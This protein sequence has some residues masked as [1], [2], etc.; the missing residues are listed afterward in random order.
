M[1]KK[2]LLFFSLFFCFSLQAQF[3][4]VLISPD[5]SD[6]KYKVKE[7]VK[8]IVQVYNNQVLL[9]NAV[10]DYELGPEFFPSVKKQ[11]VVLKGGKTLLKSRMEEPGFLRC[12]VT[13]KVEGKSY[14]GMVT[15]AVEA[16]K[17]Q[18][19]TTNP[20]DFD[21]FWN[22]E[23]ANARKL[24]LDAKMALMPERCTSTQNVYHVNF[25]NELERSRIYGILIV[26]KKPGKY[27]AVLQVPGAG[28]SPY[29]GLNLG[30]D[31]ITLEIGIHGIPVNLPREVYDALGGTVLREYADVN[32]NNKDTYFYK[33]VYIGCVRAID[34]LHSLP[35]FD[36][37]TVGVTGGSQG[38]AL[39]IIT[40]ALDPRIKFLAVFHPALC[41]NAGYL[42]HRAGGW[43]H[44][45]LKA[46]PEPGEI[47]TLAY[48]DVVNFARRLH[49]TGWY[50][51]GYNDQLCPPTSM[52]AA[53]N[54]ITAPKELHLYPLTGHWTC[55]EQLDFRIEWLRQQCLGK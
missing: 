31:I 4:D 55:Q 13:A 11:N 5:H 47:E 45:F 24:P 33:R 35:E 1:K 30:D 21:C 37:Q 42:H 25:L 54:I 23:I 39:S 12:R 53:Y 38:G 27:P 29:S 17:I 16:D 34:F 40:A 3:V 26:P 2:L 19:L 28:V 8:F 49:A 9:D 50:S 15:V 43:P 10:I 52:F 46:K 41:D 51:W 6:W 20:D 44:Y 18:P 36:G 22:E 48:F 7:D 32:K 14:E